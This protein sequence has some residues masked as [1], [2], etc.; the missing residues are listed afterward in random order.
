[1]RFLNPSTVAGMPFQRAPA[2]SNPDKLIGTAPIPDRV[3]RFVEHRR[4]SVSLATSTG[5]VKHPADKGEHPP[6]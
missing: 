2:R 4:R 1:V 3:Q 6:N 5:R